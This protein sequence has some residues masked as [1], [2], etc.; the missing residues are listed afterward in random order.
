[1][2]TVECSGEARR[3]LFLCTPMKNLEKKKTPSIACKIGATLKGNKC[4]E[5]HYGLIWKKLL[6]DVF[7]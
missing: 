4:Q 1:M 2:D 3:E 6:T 5:E 7:L